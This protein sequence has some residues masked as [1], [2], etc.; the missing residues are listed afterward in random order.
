MNASSDTF[1]IRVNNYHDGAT[2]DLYHVRVSA[3]VADALSAV[4]SS[5]D[6]DLWDPRDP[7]MFAH[8]TV[9]SP[10]GRRIEDFQIHSN[11]DDGRIS[12]SI[13]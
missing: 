10:A 13:A 5:V 11:V 4:E 8:C 9:W 1:C 7:N 3:A 12:V 2:F 6:A